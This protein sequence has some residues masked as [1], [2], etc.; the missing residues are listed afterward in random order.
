M[1]AGPSRMGALAHTKKKHWQLV[2]MHL[3][4]AAV[5]AAMHV[6]TDIIEMRKTQHTRSLCNRD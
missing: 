1:Y 5:S 3:V 2:H 6:R 4:D